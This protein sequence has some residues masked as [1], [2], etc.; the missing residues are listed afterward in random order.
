MREKS[1]GILCLVWD[2]MEGPFCYLSFFC[3]RAVSIAVERR[4]GK[5][6]EVLLL[7]RLTA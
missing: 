7:R 3:P 4:R 6:E 5:A 2:D 1:R